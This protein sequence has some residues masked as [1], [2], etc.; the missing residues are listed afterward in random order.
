[1]RRRVGLLDA[2]RMSAMTSG[3]TTRRVSRYFGDGGPFGY[4]SAR[5]VTP[6]LLAGHMPFDVVTLGISRIKFKLARDCNLDVA[7]LV[8]EC[9]TFRGRQFYPLNEIIYPIDQHFVISLRPETVAVVDGIPNL[10]FL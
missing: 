10:I 1:M 6:V 2:S 9:E 5:R 8:S 4:G 3:E 7:K